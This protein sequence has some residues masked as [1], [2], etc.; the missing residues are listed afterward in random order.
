MRVA[1]QL[2]EVPLNYLPF[3]S[4]L[5]RE[6]IYPKACP[7]EPEEYLTQPVESSGL[8]IVTHRQRVVQ[9]V[10][11]QS[12]FGLVASSRIKMRGSASRARAMARRCRCPPL[13]LTPRSPITV[14]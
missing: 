4:G 2:F 12:I 7:G 14:P 3:V 5:D 13:S 8:H 11:T 1:S 6:G 9:D 10:Y